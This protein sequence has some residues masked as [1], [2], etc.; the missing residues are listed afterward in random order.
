[1]STA[2]MAYSELQATRL[3]FSGSAG[4]NNLNKPELTALILRPY[5]KK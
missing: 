1:M 4:F 2:S 5:L 3:T